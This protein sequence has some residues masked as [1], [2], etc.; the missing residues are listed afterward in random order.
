[1][2]TEL[3]G[4]PLDWGR[5]AG[6]GSCTRFEHRRDL[7]KVKVQEISS[8]NGTSLGVFDE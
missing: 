4:F 7:V 2:A 3:Q 1:M 6:V 8:G 5:G